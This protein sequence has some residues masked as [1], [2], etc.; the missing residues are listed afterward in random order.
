M[1]SEVEARTGIGPGPAQ[2]ARERELVADRRPAG[3]PRPV[4]AVEAQQ[5]ARACERAAGDA[6]LRGRS[7]RRD[8]GAREEMGAGRDRSGFVDPGRWMVER[9]ETRS[10]DR[11]PGNE[12]G[13]GNGGKHG[14]T[15]PR[16]AREQKR[17][18]REA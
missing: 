11:T 8:S 9:V 1:G 14:R 10:A 4:P 2:A 6:G 17:G 18:C 16:E 7:E 5:D 12:Q 15:C 3:E 13:G